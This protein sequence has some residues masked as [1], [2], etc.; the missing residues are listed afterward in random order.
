M[1]VCIIWTPENLNDLFKTFVD[2]KVNSSIIAPLYICVQ[3]TLATDLL[4]SSPQTPPLSSFHSVPWDDN[5]KVWLASC[6]RRWTSAAHV[7]RAKKHCGWK[8]NESCLTIFCAF[9]GS[10]GKKM[11]ASN[12][13]CLCW[14]FCRFRFIWKGWLGRGRAGSFCPS[15]TTSIVCLIKTWNTEKLPTFNSLK[16]SEV[17]D[18]IFFPHV[19]L[20]CKVFHA[21][22]F[23][24]HLIFFDL[25]VYLN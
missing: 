9:V 20:S 23:I 24:L 22:V 12:I 18:F 7:A 1:T 19:V 6:H 3:T 17:K 13:C 16:I 2:E 21:T 14:R 5:V 25:K 8:H 4:T 10:D 11:K 15:L